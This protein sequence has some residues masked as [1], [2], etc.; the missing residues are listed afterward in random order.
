MH[1]RRPRLIGAALAAA[2]ILPTIPASAAHAVTV[3][4]GYR[5]EWKNLR[6]AAGQAMGHVELWYSPANGGTNCVVTYDD[7]S[8]SNNMKAEVQLMGGSVRRDAGYYG[9]YAGP[10][11]VTGADRKCVWFYGELDRFGIYYTYAS[12]W[13][14]CS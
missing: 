11:T 4:P 8:G 3:C 5:L 14:H 12:G 10:V 1:V 6:N 7:V 2:F 13:G 9:G